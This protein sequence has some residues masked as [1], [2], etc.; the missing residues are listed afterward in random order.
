MCRGGGSS[1][2]RLIRCC[3]VVCRRKSSRSFQP[4]RSCSCSC[5]FSRSCPSFPE[6]KNRLVRE[7]RTIPVPSVSSRVYLAYLGSSR[8]LND[9]DPS[10]API[11]VSTSD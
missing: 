6:S 5:S 7:A 4:S 9:I 10:A 11:H 3:T 8:Y 1:T 2:G